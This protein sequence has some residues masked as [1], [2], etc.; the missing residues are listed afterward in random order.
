MMEMNLFDENLAE[1]DECR[2]GMGRDVW[3]L[4]VD[5]VKAAEH[6]VMRQGHLCSY[7]YD[8]RRDLRLLLA[9]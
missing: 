8:A 7:T 3:C 1:C 4:E 6:D 9:E 2:D 5:C